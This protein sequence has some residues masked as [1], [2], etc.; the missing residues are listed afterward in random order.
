VTDPRPAP[1]EAALEALGDGSRRAILEI[2]SS[3]GR[4]V[5]QIADGLE[6][7]R[8]AVSRHLRVLKAAG[9]VT[10]RAEGARRI[11]RLDDDGVDAVRRYFARVWADAAPRFRLAAENLT[12]APEDP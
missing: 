7:S 8:P 11:Y 12:P 5:Q 2:L 9:L 10:D 3:G 6:I 4:S 1:H